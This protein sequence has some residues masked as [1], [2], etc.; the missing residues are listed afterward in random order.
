MKEIRLILGDQLNAAHSWFR[1]VDPD[2]LY[3]MAELRQE[4]DYAQHHLQKVLAFF[5]SMR[6]FAAALRAA[7]QGVAALRRVYRFVKVDVLMAHGLE[8]QGV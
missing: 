7:G 6:Q 5:A 1:R 2:V 4:T 3:V 8:S